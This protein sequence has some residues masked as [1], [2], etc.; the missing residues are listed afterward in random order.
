MM[1]DCDF[2]EDMIS[3]R[4]PDVEQLITQRSVEFKPNPSQRSLK[5]LYPSFDIG[6]L[7]LDSEKE[8]NKDKNYSSILVRS[9]KF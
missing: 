6:K 8:S 9:V 5:H 3:E 1:E 7:L 2:E 4:I